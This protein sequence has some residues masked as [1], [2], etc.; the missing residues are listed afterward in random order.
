MAYSPK[1]QKAY[2]DKCKVI[3]IK[4]SETDMNEYNRIQKYIK[5]NGVTITE[6]LKELIKTDLDEKKAPY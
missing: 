3:R 2:N 5:D 4:Y 1:S 6:Y